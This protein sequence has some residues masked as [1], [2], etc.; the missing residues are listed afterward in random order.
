M[1]LTQFFTKVIRRLKK[2]K[3]RFAVAGGLIAS[4]YRENERLTNDLDFLIFSKSK[5]RALA[6][7]IIT[8]FKLKPIVI[9]KADLEGGPMFAIKRKSTKPF[10]VCGRSSD[11]KPRIGLDFILPEMPWF[12]KALERAEINK[13][14]FGIGDPVP[15]LTVEDVILAK[16][17]AFQNKP[18]RFNDL[19]DL[20]SIFQTGHDLD[21]AYLCHEMKLLNLVIPKEL[22]SDAPDVL[23]KIKAE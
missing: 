16:L 21:L 20:Q 5:T 23:R 11:D 6:E 3:I 22:K 13:I 9:R 2:E 18:H 17:Y 8:D 10:M 1:E 19:D 7:K 15:S 14:D 12:Q 4:V